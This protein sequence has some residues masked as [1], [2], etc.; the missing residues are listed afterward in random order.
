M[1]V[2]GGKREEEEEKEMGRGGPMPKVEDTEF[3][4]QCRQQASGGQW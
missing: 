2:W 4:L 3:E 1:G